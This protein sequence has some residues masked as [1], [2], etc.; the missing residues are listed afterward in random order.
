MFEHPCRVQPRNPFEVS[1]FGAFRSLSLHSDGAVKHNYLMGPR[2]PTPA[3]RI[4]PSPGQESVWDFPAPPQVEPSAE[5]VVVRFGGQA[6]AD[7]GDAVRVLETSHPPVYYLPRAAFAEGVLVEG[8]GTSVV[9]SK[10][11]G[12]TSTCGWAEPWRD[13]PPGTTQ[14]P[15]A[16]SLP[17]D[18]VTPARRHAAV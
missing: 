3:T 11:R 17:T 13:V 4:L 15:R 10:G 1:L 2:P 12:G 16:S 5:R 18:P 8:P 6:V 7:S 14:P 9:S